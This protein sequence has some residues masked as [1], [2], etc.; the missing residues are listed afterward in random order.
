M[1]TSL[2]PS[3]NKAVFL[4][5]DGVL[6]VERGEYTFRT[7][8]FEVEQG[9]PEALT[10]L[11]QAGYFLI[12]ITNQAGIAKGLY[13]KEEVLA[14]HAKL[15]D[16]CGHLIDALYLAP[17]H[18]SVSESLSRK[19][20]SLLLER[21]IAKYKLSPEVS[22]MVGDQVRD[23][24]AAAK[25]GVSGILVGPHPNGTHVFQQANLLEAAN[26]IIAQQK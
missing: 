14:C 7:Q 18:P 3:Q 25:C 10:L 2:Q 20:G 16:A 26:W 6:N 11:K 19:P 22:W 5:R 4:D 1:N 15:Q 23:I 12:V 8:D 9:V 13:T 24:Q 17:G 21:A